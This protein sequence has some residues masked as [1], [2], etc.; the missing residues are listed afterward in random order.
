MGHVV[1]AKGPHLAVG[2]LHT[3]ADQ[4][5]RITMRCSSRALSVVKRSK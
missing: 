2:A 1:S 4:V 3:M 5:Y